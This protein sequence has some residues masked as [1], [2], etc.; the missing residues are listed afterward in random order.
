MEI[1]F[2]K[3]D[4]TDAEILIEIYNSAFYSDFIKYGECPAY[5]RTKEQMEQSIR[6]FP[7]FL[8]MCDTKPVGCISCKEMETGI[9]EVGCL[10][11]IPEFQGKGIGTAA[12]QFAK[13]HFKD[14]KRFTLIT[15]VDKKQ[16][17]R[18]YTEKCGFKI[19]ST[20]M[21]GNV[22]VVRFV[23]ERRMTSHIA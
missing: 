1:E 5:G 19:Q 9:Y 20:E 15:P 12:M 7:K 10:C 14:W 4:I 23:L 21:D 18:F 17:V 2:K 11:V 16:N 22:K 13:S 3:A 8:I 6:E